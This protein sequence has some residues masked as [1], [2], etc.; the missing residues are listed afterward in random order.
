LAAR[1]GTIGKK[2]LPDRIE[3][4]KGGG[5]KINK[6]KNGGGVGVGV[7][8]IIGG[9]FT[10]TIIFYFLF[11]SFSFVNFEYG[12]HGMDGRKNQCFRV[13]RAFR[14]QTVILRRQER[15]GEAVFDGL[16]VGVLK[17]E[18]F[19]YA[20]HLG[21]A[22]FELAVELGTLGVQGFVDVEVHVLDLGVLLPCV[23]C[24][25]S[26]DDLDTV[27]LDRAGVVLGQV[28]LADE[29][30]DG[31]FYFRTQCVNAFLT[32]VLAQHSAEHLVDNC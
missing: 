18:G 19:A 6:S 20:F 10:T 17:F 16:G 14:T 7:R 29:F 28:T 12:I 9:I 24:R 15:N 2:H 25:A 26:H 13:F 4:H 32:L 23:G 30:L 3:I 21:A 8:G 11:G 5:V 31:F 1:A 27:V 22:S